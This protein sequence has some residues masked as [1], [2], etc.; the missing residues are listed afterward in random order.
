M[1]WKN[2]SNETGHLEK[3]DSR[4]RKKP[5]SFFKHTVKKQKT[6]KRRSKKQYFAAVVVLLIN[7][8]HIF[9]EHLEDH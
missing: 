3:K 1:R 8:R 7:F 9:H 2:I 6:K 5:F 4:Y